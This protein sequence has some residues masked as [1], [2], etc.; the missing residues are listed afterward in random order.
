MTAPAPPVTISLAKC[1]EWR[2]VG[3]EVHLVLALAEGT[4]KTDVLPEG[5]VLPLVG[6]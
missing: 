2:V 4:L 6:L 1:T 5:S 3:V